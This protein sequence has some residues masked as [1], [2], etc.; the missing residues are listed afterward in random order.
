M[1]LISLS[2][3]LPPSLSHISYLALALSRTLSHTF[4]QA[5]TGI[6]GC[7][8]TVETFV[9]DDVLVP[10]QRFGHNRLTHCPL[11]PR[12]HFSEKEKESLL[13]SSFVLLS[14]PELSDTKGYEP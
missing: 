13:T 7:F 8:R 4:V 10:V 1:G 5:N 11:R 3:S 9:A 14:S 2:L 12:P 6:R